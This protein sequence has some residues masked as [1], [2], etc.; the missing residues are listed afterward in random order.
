MRVQGTELRTM[1][2]ERT[3]FKGDYSCCI[4]CSPLMEMGMCLYNY[5]IY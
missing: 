2:E 1:L 5:K 4:N 3:V